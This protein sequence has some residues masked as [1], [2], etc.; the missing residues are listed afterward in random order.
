MPDTILVVDDEVDFCETLRDVLEDANYAVCT[1]HTG[2]DALAEVALR[3]GD[4]GAILLDIRMPGM[5]GMEVLPRL[6]KE[7]PR[8]PVV[9]LTGVGTVDLAVQAM[10]LGAQNFL[11]KPPDEERLLL[12]VGNAIKKRGMQRTHEVEVARFAE[13][14]VVGT[15]EATLKILDEVAL[16]APTDIS[17]LITG[18]TGVGKDVIARAVHRLSKRAKRP[19]VTADIP[20][21]P[22]Q[23]FESELFGHTRGAFTGAI[24]DKPGL[25]HAAHTGTLFLDEIGELP[26]E[27]QPKFLRVLQDKMV[28]KLHATRSDEV[29]VRIISATNRDLARSVQQRAFREDL[30]YRLRGVEIYIPP[31]RE[32]IDDI[33]VLAQHFIEKACSRHGLEGRRLSDSALDFLTNQTWP[34]NVRELELFIERAAVFAPSEVLDASYLASAVGGRRPSPS[35]PRSYDEID[36]Q[37][38]HLTELFKREEL[39]T[40]LQKN[41]WNITIAAA[42][43]HIDR[44]TLS[45]QMKRLNIVKP[46]L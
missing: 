36:E 45:K 46:T 34:G 25:F 26:F 4:I 9:M 30:Y 14:G 18:E 24:D 42:E 40:V 44:S 17:V 1:V 2:Q 22:S 33:P 5:S 35:G 41:H 39:I 13:A 38:H 32:R 6:T 3:K 11:E 43:L 28:K 12:A 20:S 7:Y 8:I 27:M 15:S 29:D 21:I 10:Q 16:C 19:F 37:A 31:L 23:M